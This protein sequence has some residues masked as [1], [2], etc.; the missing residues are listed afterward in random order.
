MNAILKRITI[1]QESQAFLLILLAS[2]L[3]FNN[4]LYLLVPCAVLFYVLYNLQQPNK[5]GIFSVIALQHFMQIIAA[6]ILCNYLG[7]DINYNTP[8]RSTAVVAASIGL[9]FLLA[10][11]YY[12][13]SKIPPQTI[14]SLRQYAARLSTQKIMNLYIAA[15]FITNSLA[16]VAFLF[17]GLT[18]IIFSLVKVKW[19]LFLLFGFQCMLKNERKSMFYIFV[20][21]EFLSG[22]ISYFSEF[23]IVLYYLLFLIITFVYELKFK[24][25]I[26]VA[27]IG[28]LLAAFALVWTNIKGEYRKFL[29]A[30]STQQVVGVEGN[31]ALD[32]LYDLS[33]KVDNQ[34][35]DGSVVQFLDRLQYT[36]HFA[37]AI[38]RVPAGVPFQNGKNW[39]TSLEFA[40]TPRFLNPNKP[41]YSA[42][43]KAIKY[44]GLQY[45]GAK[46]GV[47]FSLGYFADAYVDLGLYGMMLILLILGTIYGNI[48][49]YLMRNAS[50]NLV[51]NYAVV[52]AFFMEFNAIEMDST[53]VLGRLFASFV[54]FFALIKVFFPWVM[55]YISLQE[56]KVVKLPGQ[57]VANAAP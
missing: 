34:K 53:L 22:F 42:T 56:E 32:K 52:G 4:G 6:V 20:T 10:P 9:I 47:S 51:F 16:A 17:S 27:I 23:K 43:E 30:G 35:L 12:F 15:F 57:T 1:D 41:I 8:S 37:K 40:T 19:M 55:N 31:E 50:T 21:F 24:Q 5:P 49:Y 36:Y 39:L 48:Y 2:L 7:K 45:R 44:T 46:W 14:S 26:I 25:I 38:D 28:T 54:T 33:S 18:Q 13:Q 3:L 29:N 11:V